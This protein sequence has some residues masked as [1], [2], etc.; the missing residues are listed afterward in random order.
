MEKP[1]IDEFIYLYKKL[2]TVK[3]LEEEMEY[4]KED[5]KLIRSIPNIIEIKFIRLNITQ[6]KDKI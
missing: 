5:L 3:L 1:F 2:K 4:L 6:I